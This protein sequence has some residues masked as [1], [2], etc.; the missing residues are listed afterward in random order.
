[1][2]IFYFEW[3][4]EIDAFVFQFHYPKFSKY[5]FVLSLLV[6]FLFN[7]QYLLT[8]L[9]LIALGI[10]F[11]HSKY[12]EERVQPKIIAMFFDESLKH[13]LLRHRNGVKKQDEI[14]Y[15][16]TLK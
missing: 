3:F 10:V 2:I 15:Q 6:T 11:T 1:M 9:V 4:L 7:P 8:Y 12:Y 5:A 14:S 16:S 13:P